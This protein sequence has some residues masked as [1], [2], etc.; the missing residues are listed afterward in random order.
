MGFSR[1]QTNSG[2]LFYQAMSVVCAADR[3]LDY[4]LINEYRPGQG[5]L[6]HQVT[7][8]YDCLCSMYT[9]DSFVGTCARKECGY[10]LAA[11]PHTRARAGRAVVPATRGH[12]QSGYSLS[13]EVPVSVCL[14]VCIAIDYG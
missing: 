8:L 13:T 11:N 10:F 2:G 14:S 5:I 4:V 7:V 9:T 12:H 1:C 6:P 3:A